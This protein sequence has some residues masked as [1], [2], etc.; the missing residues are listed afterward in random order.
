[1]RELRR[2]PLYLVALGTLLLAGFPLLWMGYTALK[3]N[4]QIS[5]NV[6]ALPHPPTGENLVQAWQ[7][8]G[9]RRAYFNSLLVAV[10]AGLMAALFSAGAGYAFARLRFRGREVLFYLFLAGMVLPIHIT[11]IPLY[12]LLE[13]LGLRNTYGALLGP[14][15]A[16]ALPVSILILR[17]FFAGLPRELEEAAVLD[18][19]SVWGRFWRLALPLSRPAMATVVIFNFVAMW[20]ELVFA[21]TFIDRPHL[22]TLPLALMEF[23]A[24]HGWDLAGV[25]AALVLAVYPALGVYFLAQRHI[26][27]GLTAGALQ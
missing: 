22:R 11:L 1:M 23:S 25:N 15:T 19:C 2:W 7:S 6:W 3:T 5:A 16:F 24:E 8:G 18:G 26:I 10:L 14:Y 13:R 9:F 12:T 20:N 27:R 17:G 4:A 21:L